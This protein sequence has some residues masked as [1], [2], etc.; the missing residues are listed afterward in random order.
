[1]RTRKQRARIV[2]RGVGVGWGFVLALPLAAALIVFVAQNTG[3]VDVRWTV[4]KVHTP[5][6]VVVLVAI[7]AAVV[8][9]EVVG[10]IWRHRRRRVLGR[11]QAALEDAEP[12]T[13]APLPAPADAG[14]STVVA[15]AADEADDATPPARS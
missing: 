8:L 10:V 12:E 5:L 1:M 3:D 15:P 7:L 4:W 2:H 11:Q 9:A 6:A 14:D 13:P